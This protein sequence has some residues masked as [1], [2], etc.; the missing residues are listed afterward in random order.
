MVNIKIRLII[1]FAAKDGEALYSWQKQDRELTMAQIVK[2]LLPNSDLN[3][4]V[5]KTT[6]SFRY[7]LNQ[8]PYDYTVKV[9][10]GFKGLDLIDRVPDELWMEVHDIVQETGIKTISKKK[11]CKKAKWLSEEAWQIALKRREVK[12]KG[13][14]ERYTHLN[15]ELQRI[16][17]RD[18][19][20]FLND[21]CKEIEE[22]NRM[23]KTRDLF[24]TLE[25]PREHFMQRW[26]W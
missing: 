3:W 25:I 6:R 13:E 8:I 19:E 5:G 26:A 16:A 21:Q 2:S 7:D 4:R 23:G 20:S 15:A 18:E 10:N 9:R 1:F 24:K 14:K 17:R 22:N 12:S 11:K